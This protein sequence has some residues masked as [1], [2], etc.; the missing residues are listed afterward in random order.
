MGFAEAMSDDGVLS[1][2]RSS[3]GARD[4]LR[5]HDHGR[6]HRSHASLSNFQLLLG[7]VCHTTAFGGLH[8]F[9]VGI[10]IDSA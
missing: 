10:L 7:D 4:G 5:S 9:I 8:V 1:G 6:R 2:S 3:L